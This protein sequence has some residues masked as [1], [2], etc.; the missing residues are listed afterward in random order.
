MLA[1]YKVSPVHP[2]SQLQV[3]AREFAAAAE[4]VLRC[5]QV[6]HRQRTAAG[7]HTAGHAH[8]Q[9]VQA[10]LQLQRPRAKR[11]LRRGIEK[12]RGRCKKSKAIVG[13]CRSRQ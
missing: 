1:A 3:D 8:C 12:H 10:A 9:H 4:Q 13:I 11:V 7:G 5:A 6:H 2:G